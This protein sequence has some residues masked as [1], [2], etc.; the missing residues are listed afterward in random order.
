MAF[1]SG[2]GKELPAEGKFCPGCGKP[3]DGTSSTSNGASDP[4]RILKE[5]EFRRWDK[6][7]SLTEDAKLT[8]F[9][10]RLEWN[11]KKIETIKID[12]IANVAVGIVNM[13]ANVPTLEFT[14]NAGKKRRFFRNVNLGKKMQGTIL[15]AGG[16]NQLEITQFTNAQAEMESWRAAIDKLRGRL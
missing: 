6:T 15:S 1:C 4:T 8:L 9:C 14:D 16:N 3:M 10:D 11:G 12:D 13:G 7:F 2:C 5:G